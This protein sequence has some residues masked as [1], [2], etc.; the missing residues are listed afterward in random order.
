M[1][2]L[3]NSLFFE[4]ILKICLTFKTLCD[5]LSLKEVRQMDLIELSNSMIRYRAEN[6]ISQVEF[7]KQ[8]KLS[9]QTICNIEN[10]KQ[11]PNKITMY[12]ILDRIGKNNENL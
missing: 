5:I 3:D 2:V 10:C 7:A 11:K 8:C 12:K 4:K 9:Q 1:R 6:A